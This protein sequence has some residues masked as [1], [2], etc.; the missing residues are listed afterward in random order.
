MSLFFSLQETSTSSGSEESQPN[1]NFE[2]DLE[3]EDEDEDEEILSVFTKKKPG[4]KAGR[5]GKW[6]ESL[7][8]DM[9]DII[10]NSEYYRKNLIFTNTKNQKNGPIY[11]SILQQLKTRNE[12]VPFSAVQL[13]NKFKKATAE[14][15]KVA[16]TI[17]T[18]SGIKRFQ[19]EKNY[20]QWFNQLFALVK[21]RD[22]CQPEQAIE[23]SAD[24]QSEAT[25]CNGSKN[26]SSGSSED[27]FVPIKRA[28][29]K[30]KGDEAFKEIIDVVKSMIDKDPMKEYLEFAR[31]EAAQARQHE[32]RMMEMFIAMQ[33]SHPMHQPQQ[34]YPGIQPSNAGA[35]AGFFR[36]YLD[37]EEQHYGQDNNQS[38][39]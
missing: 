37:R 28:G 4:K 19:D 31:E 10:V 26:S 30:R 8:S 38:Y 29:K 33:S 23:P 15:K 25:A 36:N 16:L 2:A 6:N 34:I 35:N 39:L 22:S 27:M 20:G 7:L 11:E 12:S 17:K 3:S 13:R 24:L 14:C 21:T 5:K 1:S 9:V 32:A 18:A